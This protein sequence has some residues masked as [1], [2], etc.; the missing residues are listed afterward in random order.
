[1]SDMRNLVESV[2]EISGRF[3]E[4][5]S[6][7]VDAFSVESTMKMIDIE[8]WDVI[9]SS[10]TLGDSFHRAHLHNLLEFLEPEGLDFLAEMVSAEIKRRG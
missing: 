8:D 7:L 10:A 4:E 1:M 9:I 3:H 5:L 2:R 6:S